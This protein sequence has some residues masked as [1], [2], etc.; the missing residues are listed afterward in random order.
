MPQPY[1]G[2]RHPVEG[3]RLDHGIERHVFQDELV[4]LLQGAVKGIVADDVAGEAGRPAE[5]IGKRLFLRFAAAL[6]GRAVG[7]FQHV[8]HMAGGRNVQ[9][10][11]VDPVV[12]RLQHVRVQ[13]PRVEDDRFPG[14]EIDV[15][16]IFFAQPADD[17]D[18][19]VPIVAV[20]RDVMPAAEVEPAHTGGISSEFFPKS[21]YGRFQRVRILFA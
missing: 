11:D 2:Q 7:H 10:G 14:F 12:H 9:N 3:V 15:R 19:S 1:G 18:Q 17:A 16:A 6:Q 8:R 5:P 4:A 13:R 21:L 20:P